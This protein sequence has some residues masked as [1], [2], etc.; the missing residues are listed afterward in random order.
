M[1]RMHASKGDGALAIDPGRWTAWFRLAVVALWCLSAFTQ[2]HDPRLIARV[3]NAA[4]RIRRFSLVGGEFDHEPKPTGKEDTAPRL[5]ANG[6]SPK[7]ID[8]LRS[9]GNSQPLNIRVTAVPRPI[10]V[11]E[12]LREELIFRFAFF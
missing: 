1:F 3:G 9:R 11:T 12:P 7:K 10:P 6:G 4:L 8:G 5:T 2:Q